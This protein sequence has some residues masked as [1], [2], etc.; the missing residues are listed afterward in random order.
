MITIDIHREGGVD[1]SF[2]LIA[3]F[4]PSL[5]PSIS[6]QILLL[7]NWLCCMFFLYLYTHLFQVL[8]SYSS[9]KLTN[10][11]NYL[12]ISNHIMKF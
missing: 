2:S 5:T 7:K 4:F 8:K 11:E 9:A 12:W 1:A 10:F 3:K 6:I